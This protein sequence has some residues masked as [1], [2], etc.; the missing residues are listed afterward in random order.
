MAKMNYQRKQQSNRYISFQDNG[1]DVATPKQISYMGK[2]GIPYHGG[3]TR[4]ECSILINHTLRSKG[5][6]TN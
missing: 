6:I 3:M 5:K 2:L 4:K 1:S